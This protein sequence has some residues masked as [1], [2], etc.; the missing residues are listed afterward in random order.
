ML[1]VRIADAW[2]VCVGKQEV[3]CDGQEGQVSHQGEVLAVH[4][5]VVQPV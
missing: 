1:A 3:E 5:H 2:Y 4:N